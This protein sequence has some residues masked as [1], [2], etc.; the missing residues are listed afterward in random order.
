MAGQ[1]LILLLV[2]DLRCSLVGGVDVAAYLAVGQFP[3]LI[4]GVLANL[5]ELSALQEELHHVRCALVLDGF[6]GVGHG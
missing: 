2:K 1:E 3:T 6:V 4:G 5:I